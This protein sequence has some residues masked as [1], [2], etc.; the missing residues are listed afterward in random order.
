[1]EAEKAQQEAD[2]IE[3]AEP[4]V[5]TSLKKSSRKKVQETQEKG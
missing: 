3:E 4:V 5:M 1:M 2:D